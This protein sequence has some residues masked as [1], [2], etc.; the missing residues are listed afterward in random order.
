M[1]FSK[2]HRPEVVVSCDVRP[3]VIFV[4]GV[5]VIVIAVVIICVAVA[6]ATIAGPGIAVVTFSI[7]AATIA[8]PGIAVVTF[9]IVIVGITIISSVA[10]PVIVDLEKL[11]QR[12]YKKFKL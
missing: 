5:S 8:G 4:V 10:V 12:K 1:S 3:S 6:A 2:F 7:A 9:S 11:R